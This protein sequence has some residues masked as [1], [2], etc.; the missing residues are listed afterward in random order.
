MWR[1]RHHGHTTT[2]PPNC[3]LTTT[4]LP[5]ARTRPTRQLPHAATH[6]LNI[7][8]SLLSHLLFPPAYTCTPLIPVTS[9]RWWSRGTLGRPLLTILEQVQLTCPNPS[10]WARQPSLTRSSLRYVFTLSSFQ[11]HTSSTLSCGSLGTVGCILQELP[12]G[13]LHMPRG[14]LLP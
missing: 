6:S 11:K 13:A 4:T 1:Q 10:A 3:L 7:P 5:H 8:T 2:E 12:P 14:C 9:A